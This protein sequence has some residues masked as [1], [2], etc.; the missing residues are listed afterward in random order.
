MNKTK[1][2]DYRC[3][4]KQHRC[5]DAPEDDIEFVNTVQ[6]MFVLIA[7]CLQAVEQIAKLKLKCVYTIPIH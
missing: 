1:C 2:Q 6:C 5:Q 3:L 7:V 4:F